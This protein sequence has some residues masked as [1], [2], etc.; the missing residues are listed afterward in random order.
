MRRGVALDDDVGYRVR[1]GIEDDVSG[2][3]ESAIR[4][5]HLG[6]DGYFHNGSAIG[7]D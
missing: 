4:G 5:M 6:V 2:T 1:R 7:S 3:T